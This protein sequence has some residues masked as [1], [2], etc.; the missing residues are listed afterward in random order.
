MLIMWSIIA[1]WVSVYQFDFSSCSAANDAPHWYQSLVRANKPKETE[2]VKMICE[3]C[4]IETFTETSHP[5]I[6]QE[7]GKAKN[8][9]KR[10]YIE[11]YEMDVDWIIND[12]LGGIETI[13]E[14][15]DALD[16]YQRAKADPIGG[17][18][19]FLEEYLAEDGE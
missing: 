17:V 7:C 4:G 12:L 16:L 14:K 5:Y 10:F 9:V 8:N 1:K 18:D 6:T 13:I 19:D 2:I 11:Q 15:F 3:Y